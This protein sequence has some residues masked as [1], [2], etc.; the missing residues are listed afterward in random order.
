MED[1]AALLGW[2][3]ILAVVGLFEAWLYS[4]AF[5]AW[6]FW[7]LFWAIIGWGLAFGFIRWLF[8]QGD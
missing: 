1:F 8:K 6:G 2:L 5:V 3:V 7:G 4:S